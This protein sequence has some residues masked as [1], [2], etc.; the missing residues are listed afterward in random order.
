MP[1][2]SAG[3]KNAG[4]RD[5]AK[6][7]ETRAA[8]GEWRTRKCEAPE[9]GLCYRPRRESLGE[10]NR[11]NVPDYKNR[12][13]RGYA[14]R[15]T[16]DSDRPPFPKERTALERRVNRDRGSQSLGSRRRKN[17]Q[18]ATRRSG[19]C[20]SKILAYGVLDRTQDALN[21]DTGHIVGGWPLD[22]AVF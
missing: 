2:M 3:C 9:F 20:R 4:D 7:Q 21:G 10:K 15:M 13:P 6:D 12:E 1:A 5:K 8:D 14:A 11:K 17:H 18:V 22:G 16:A 19:T